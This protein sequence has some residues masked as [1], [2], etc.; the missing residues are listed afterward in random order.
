MKVFKE[1]RDSDDKRAVDMLNDMEKHEV[2]IEGYSIVKY[3]CRERT[4][5]LVSYLVEDKYECINHDWGSLQIDNV[6]I[7]ICRNCSK[8]KGSVHK[9][10]EL[11]ENN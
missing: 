3:E 5:I 2:K 11:L 1:L 6:S 4:C 9:N 10:T 7:G 8:I